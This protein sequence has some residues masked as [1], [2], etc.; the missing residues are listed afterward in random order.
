MRGA[1][2]APFFLVKK[3]GI[4]LFG[5]L[6]I[7]YIC[8]GAFAH[9]VYPAPYR[10]FLNKYSKMYELDPLLMGALIFTESRFQENSVSPAGAVG[11]MQIMPLTAVEI[12][13]DLG[14]KDFAQRDLFNE[15]INI[16]MGCYYL[17]KL[18][19]NLNMEEPWWGLAAYNAGPIFF[20][21]S[22]SSC[23]GT[24]NKIAFFGGDVILKLKIE[25]TVTSCKTGFPFT[26][27]SLG[28]GFS[29]TA[30]AG[31]FDFVALTILDATVVLFVFIFEIIFFIFCF[32]GWDGFVLPFFLVELLEVD[33]FFVRKRISFLIVL[34]FFAI[35][36]LYRIYK[37]VLIIMRS[38]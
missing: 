28:N 37:I 19:K 38:K 27:D 2:E 4:I 10:S 15:E 21:F 32:I 3:L 8:A 5:S 34:P 29:E 33:F 31:N 24:A 25:S 35:G 16:Q 26:F 11:L 6:L 22:I 17:S 18:K 36:T 23:S 9:F 13:Q 1:F 30:L 12:S 20:F 14:I 7:L